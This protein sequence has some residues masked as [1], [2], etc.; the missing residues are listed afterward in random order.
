MAELERE[1]V[2][3][4]YDA[5]APHFSATRY[6]PWPVVDNFLRSLPLGS[7]GADIGCGN[8]KYMGVNKDVMI[9]GSDMSRN[10][11]QICRTR[12]FEALVADNLS[13]PYRTGSFDF[14]I[15]IAVIHHFST[16]SRRAS[17][18]REI[19]RVLRCGGRA[20]VFVWAKEQEGKRR[21]DGQ[22]VFVPWTMNAKVYGTTTAAAG[23]GAGAGGGNDAGEAGP[24]AGAGGTEGTVVYYHLFVKG[25]LESLVHEAGGLKIEAAGY[26]RD[27][28]YVVVVKED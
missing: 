24:A 26:D 19:A 20:L 23:A 21:F 9:L 27:N 1:H 18:L 5:I 15:S 14:S 11:L 6:K 7:L 4:V 12:G 16:A 2:H 25:E 10:L 22:D 8:G 28:W 3:A 13:L 17:A